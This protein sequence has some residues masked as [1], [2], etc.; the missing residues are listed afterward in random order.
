L[1][2]K[3]WRNPA[4]KSRSRIA[5]A[6][7]ARACDGFQYCYAALRVPAKGEDCADPMVA[8][9]ADWVAS[10]ATRAM[11]TAITGIENPTFTDG[12]I[13]AYG[14]GDFL[15]GHDDDLAGSGRK[16]AFV[17][18]LSPQWRLEWGGLL[19]FHEIGGVDVAGMV[20]QF[21]TVDLFKVPTYHSVSMVTAAAPRRRFSI[22]GW[23]S[24][25]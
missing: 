16:A 7:H 11:L 9:V 23:L 15:T 2:T 19:L 17:L 18:G 10:P 20:P 3:T 24:E 22:T 14:E 8:L 25:I 13:T 21:N 6:M 1:P 5:P 12:Q 4:R